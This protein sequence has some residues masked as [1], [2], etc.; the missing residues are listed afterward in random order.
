MEIRIKDPGRAIRST[1]APKKEGQGTVGKYEVRKISDLKIPIPITVS[2]DLMDRVILTRPE[3]TSISPCRGAK[4]DLGVGGIQSPAWHPYRVV[5]GHLMVV[6][7]WPLGAISL[8][9]DS[10]ILVGSYHPCQLIK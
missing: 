2:P 4:T 10:H 9:D 3:V 7:K 6:F 8:Q 1:R 5:W